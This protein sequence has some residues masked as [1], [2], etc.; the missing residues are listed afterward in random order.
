MFSKAEAMSEEN[1]TNPYAS[2][3]SVTEPARRPPPKPVPG[4]II[5]VIL[6]TIGAGIVSFI[7]WIGLGTLVLS[8]P[9]LIRSVRV[10]NRKSGVPHPQTLTD[11]SA[12]ILGTAGLVVSLLAAGVGAFWGTCNAAGWT[13]AVV[14]SSFYPGRYDWIPVAF[15]AG[16]ITGLAVGGWSMYHLSRA[17]VFSRRAPARTDGDEVL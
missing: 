12:R 5:G 7:P 1:S 4:W 2:P 14:A 13:T 17:L 15:G 16:I 10:R 11:V 9:I 6:V 8:A 3:Q